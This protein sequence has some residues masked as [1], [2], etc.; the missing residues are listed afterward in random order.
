MTATV[1]ELPGRQTE[2]AGV[3][4][5]SASDACPDVS[6]VI[7][8]YNASAVIGRALA[9]VAAQTLENYEIVIVDDASDDDLDNALGPFRH[10]GL[11]VL[12]HDANRGA[13]AARNT[14]AAAA[15]GRLIAFLD[16][17]DEWLPAKLAMQVAHLDGAPAEIQASCTGHHIERPSTSSI[18]ENRPD[19][20]P[21]QDQL[22]RFLF[23]C[24]ISPGSTLMV[25]R[26]CFA[27]VGPF[28]EAL[29]RLEDWDWLVRFAC[30]WKIGV[31]DQP[32]THVHIGRQPESRQVL[33]ALEYLSRKYVQ[34]HSPLSPGQIRRFR[35]TLLIERA[36]VFYRN[37]A[38][39]RALTLVCRSLVVYPFRN[40]A[41][42]RR[43]AYRW[44]RPVGIPAAAPVANKVVHV[45]TGLG[46]GG[47]E[48]TLT[49]VALA[50]H[51][52]GLPVSVVTLTSGGRF[53]TVLRDKGV[54]VTSLG[55]RRS[56]PNPF[57]ILRLARL[58]RRERPD[59]IQSWMYHADLAALAATYLSGRRRATRLFWGVRCSDM[60]PRRYGLQLRLLI[61]VCKTLSRLPD[62]VIANSEAGRKVHLGLGYRPRRFDVVDN[63]IDAARFASVETEREAVRRELGIDDGVPV[64]AM[65][66]RLD[67][68]KD[69]L[70]YL[71][72]LR[73]LPGVQALAIGAGTEAL[74]AT[75]GLHRLGQRDDVP[76]LLGACDILVLSSAF[77]EGF[78]N[79]I[80]EGMAAGL[81]VV[82]TDVGDVR[83]IVG[84]GGII[85]PPRDAQALAD[86]VSRLLADPTAREQMGEAG[87]QRVATEYSFAKTLDAFDEIYWP[88]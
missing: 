11:R 83:R 84:D 54:H 21:E 43:M 37:G 56:V 44:I 34:E 17:D 60:E 39:L 74:P 30:R 66:A 7:P 61:W 29:R 70:N 20:A 69:Y 27:N 64:M 33:Q 14:G 65:V 71:N 9:S 36:A 73:S 19:L 12:R 47:A 24:R 67:P 62:G 85:V 35:S 5:D 81:P 80:V 16:A 38:T 63:G 40:T 72:A 88:N 75:A 55:M 26:G 48:R 10:L 51:R 86:A 3:C 2:T 46:V 59:V 76:R 87:R 68:M 6:V 22:T 42:F 58:L 23:G 77:G 79:A 82:A 50:K 41:F 13:A 32:L 25:K 49:S 15:R 57:A 18:E 52:T 4:D 8:V 53:A 45:I 1:D 28:D 78:P 31:L